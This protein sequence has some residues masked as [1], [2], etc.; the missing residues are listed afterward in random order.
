MIAD[1]IATCKGSG[2]VYGVRSRSCVLPPALRGTAVWS[3]WVVAARPD[4]LDARESL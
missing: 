1:S 4:A 2:N 3:G